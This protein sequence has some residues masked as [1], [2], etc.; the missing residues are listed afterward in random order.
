MWR[1]WGCCR[2]REARAGVAEAHM[3][4]VA[5][6]GRAWVHDNVGTLLSHWAGLCSHPKCTGSVADELLV[7]ACASEALRAAFGRLLNEAGQTAAAGQ[8]ASLIKRGVSEAGTATASAA[9]SRGALVVALTELGHL[10]RELDGSA[11]P[12]LV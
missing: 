2:S 3:A 10:L 1:A 6:L 8:L 9:A 5:S 12:V 4:V 7:R 11:L